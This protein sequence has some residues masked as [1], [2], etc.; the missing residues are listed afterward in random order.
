MGMDV[1]GKR[2][3]SDEGE[4]FRNNVWWWHPLWEYCET[5]MP[6]LCEEISGHTNDG[7]GLTEDGAGALAAS[8]RWAVDSGHT[9]EYE[10]ARN[11]M[12]SKLP[13]ESCRY[14][15]GT[16]IRTDEV[17]KSAGMPDAVLAEEVAIVLGRT[18]GTCNACQ[19]EGVVDSPATWYH[20]ST[21]NVEEFI[22]FLEAC[23]G[24]EI[25]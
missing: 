9:A 13:R 17:G 15:E 16:G 8:L 3:T 21:E 12:L 2:P 6:E 24:F 25:W 11:E 1:V 22:D 7:Q 5:L 4:Y 18:H 19:G 20:F 14:C 23:G 10:R